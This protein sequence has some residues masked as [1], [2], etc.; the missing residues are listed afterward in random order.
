MPGSLSAQ[1]RASL[2]IADRGG[3]ALVTVIEGR[4]AIILPPLPEAD[5][6]PFLARITDALENAGLVAQTDQN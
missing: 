6:A 1:Q 5:I 2:R 3:G 4:I